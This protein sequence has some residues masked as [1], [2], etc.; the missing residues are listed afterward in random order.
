[1]PEPP[2]LRGGAGDD[3]RMAVPDGGR[4][5]PGEEIQ[6]GPPCGIPDPDALP[7]GEDQGRRVHR[8]HA[9][10]EEPVLAGEDLLVPVLRHRRRSGGAYTDLHR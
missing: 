9:G 10:E 7:L 5:N 4:E 1:M 3:L 2:H 8:A 6:V